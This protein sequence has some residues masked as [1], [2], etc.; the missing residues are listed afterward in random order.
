MRREQLML[1]TQNG[2]MLS[3]VTGRDA[4]VPFLLLNSQ[5]LRII[6]CHWFILDFHCRWELG[7][8]GTDQLGRSCL[9]DWSCSSVGVWCPMSLVSVD[10]ITGSADRKGD[11]SDVC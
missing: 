7:E 1:D 8:A 4:H 10:N 9:L 11:L 2:E 6:S 5:L 3:P